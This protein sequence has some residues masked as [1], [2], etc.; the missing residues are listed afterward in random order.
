[1]RSHRP[2]HGTSAVVRRRRA[3]ARRVALALLCACAESYVLHPGGARRGLA[4]PA[5]GQSWHDELQQHGAGENWDLLRD[6]RSE[7]DELRTKLE[8]KH[9]STQQLERER[10]NLLREVS[11]L[12]EARRVEGR[13]QE[14]LDKVRDMAMGLVHRQLEDHREMER[15]KAAQRFQT[16]SAAELERE[17][18]QRE[19]A[20]LAE[21]R[22]AESDLQR[23][24]DHVRDTAS[25]LIRERLDFKGAVEKVRTAHRSELRARDVSVER[26]RA[27]LQE[28]AAALEDKQREAE[29]EIS[30]AMERASQAA[31]KLLRERLEHHKAVESLKEAIE[32]LKESH[33]GDLRALSS[34]SRAEA[35]RLEAANAGL[36]DQLAG[37]ETSLA[38]ALGRAKD[39]ADE[40]TRQRLEAHAEH[41]A[42]V[43]DLQSAHERELEETVE[44]L[45]QDLQKATHERDSFRREA[46]RLR[47]DRK[48][49]TDRHEKAKRRASDAATEAVRL[50]L[51]HHSA[52][53]ALKDSH[54]EEVARR[55]MAAA[56]LAER[57]EAEAARRRAAEARAREAK[58]RAQEASTALTRL[59]LES[60]AEK[61]EVHEAH[62]EAHEEK[63]A[64]HAKTVAE[65]DALHAKT[66]AELEGEVMSLRGRAAGLEG[67]RSKALEEL[68]RLEE[69]S[70]EAATD[71][72]RLK[73][74]QHA[75]MEQ[76]RESHAEELRVKEAEAAALRGRLEEE[77]RAKRG[78]ERGAAALEERV[79]DAATEVQRLKLSLHAEMVELQDGHAA[80]MAESEA[81][82][83]ALAEG[84]RKEKEDLER[85]T[86]QQK[87]GL[88]ARI[89]NLEE[90]L[91]RAK[92]KT[93]AVEERAG[94]AATALVRQRLELH[95][96]A[97]EREAEQRAALDA[98]S[99]EH[100]AAA[101]RADAQRSALEAQVASARASRD[102]LRGA[103]DSLKAKESDLRRRLSARADEVAR[104]AL[105]AHRAQLEQESAFEALERRHEA[106]K[107]RAEAQKDA[108]LSRLREQKRLSEESSLRAKEAATEGVRQRLE[109]HA[110]AEAA[111]EKM[112]REAA[113]RAEKAKAEEEMLMQ[114]LRKVSQE[115][116]LEAQQKEGLA[117]RLRQ[118]SLEKDGALERLRSAQMSFQRDSDALRSQLSAESAQRNTLLQEKGALEQAK[119]ALEQEKGALLQQKSALEAE[120]VRRD[121]EMRAELSRARAEHEAELRQLRQ[122]ADF[123]A[124]RAK[125]EVEGLRAELQE[126]GE[127]MK[128]LTR[129]GESMKRQMAAYG[130]A[131]RA[132]EA[133]QVRYLNMWRDSQTGAMTRRL[134]RRPSGGFGVVEL[135][136]LWKK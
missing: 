77:A 26:E 47:A 126:K 54:S 41:H 52:A 76:T 104:A 60:H 17:A 40:V 128:K 38:A 98:L 113:E 119:G 84:L 43:E 117:G 103:V 133:N 12:D 132:A 51:D 34:A 11:A 20:V 114:R 135:W 63:D 74:A 13:L 56:A 66:V 106:E 81:A 21:A 42:R 49:H 94:A 79:K 100:A 85:Y 120:M 16:R 118:E 71:L 129:E 50:R 24:L 8:E 108:L 123:E 95:A 131:R 136:N 39:L 14:S 90:Q 125:A 116:D 105:E 127:R 4:R 29:E 83:A 86:T 57:L 44:S 99:R 53:N 102:T 15:L 6:A 46:L 73:L 23:S 69:R 75:E 78:L 55:E 96:E 1:M 7:A 112:A 2:G 89:Q 25:G 58:E 68:R 18:L 10:R 67:A 28:K 92:K 110:A 101:D 107:S 36:R 27:R 5:L 121:N 130:K 35:A 37:V 31:T 22:R 9:L 80:A 124:H 122:R 111:K 62:A 70:S 97:L 115:R 64:L 93:E 61:M 33:A 134:E 59:S 91:H 87:E 72:V 65:K 30:A 109:L 32:G 3:P 45:T 48:K 82:A 88:A 19:V